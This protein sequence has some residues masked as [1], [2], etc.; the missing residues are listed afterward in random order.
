MLMRERGSDD[1]TSFLQDVDRLLLLFVVVYQ[2]CFRH[3]IY[4][5]NIQTQKTQFMF[6]SL[7]KRV[8]RIK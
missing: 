1:S 3:V 8:T 7:S 6:P 2:Q 4:Q 5:S